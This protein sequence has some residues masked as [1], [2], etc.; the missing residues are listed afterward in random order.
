MRSDDRHWQLAGYVAG[1]WCILVGIG[2]IVLWQMA[3][4]ELAARYPALFDMKF[5]AA[6]ALTLIG[7]AFLLTHSGLRLLPTSSA[8]AL[9]GSPTR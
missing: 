3:P 6:L 8:S 1:L 5:N 9:S 7:A 4:M 2:M